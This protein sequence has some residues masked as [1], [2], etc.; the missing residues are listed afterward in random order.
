MVPR[1]R[2]TEYTLFEPWLGMGCF[3]FFSTLPPGVNPR[4]SAKQRFTAV[5]LLQMTPKEIRGSRK[6]KT[7]VK[8]FGLGKGGNG[9][10]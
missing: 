7:Y 2:I 1:I 9:P 10:L 5:S 8:S 6:M 3:F 4:T